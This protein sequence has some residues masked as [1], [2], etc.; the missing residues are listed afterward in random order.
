MSSLE[1][2]VRV[3]RWSD[4]RSSAVRYVFHA[5]LAAAAWVLAVVI[6]A[7]FIP[8]E[9]AVRVAAF[10]A[11][12]AFATIAVAWIAARPRPMRLMRTAD[13]QLGLKERLSTAWE[14]RLEDGPMDAMLRRDALEKAARARLAAKPHLRLWVFR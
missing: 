7:R 6:V 11:P 1:S 13:L 9:Q 14:R 3:L 2:V 4:A 10:G 8:L 12:F 5:L